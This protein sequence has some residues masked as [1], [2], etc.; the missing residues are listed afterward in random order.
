MFQCLLAFLNEVVPFSTAP[1]GS[2]NALLVDLPLMIKGL[3][4]LLL[5]C[6][7]LV[8]VQK[9][10]GHFPCFDLVSIVIHFTSYE[11]HSTCYLHPLGPYFQ[12][13]GGVLFGPTKG[14]NLNFLY[15]A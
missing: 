14:T 12:H 5:F 3:H 7:L 13:V 9:M 11:A 8:L 2:S 15:F 1:M 4:L 10:V 6:F